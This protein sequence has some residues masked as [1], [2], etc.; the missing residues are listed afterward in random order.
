MKIE[1]RQIPESLLSALDVNL[2]TGEI[3][4]AYDLNARARKGAIAGTCKDGYR[5]ICFEYQVWLGHRIVW[6]KAFGAQNVPDQIDHIDNNPSN[7]ALINL[8]AATQ[9]QNN[10]N[11]PARRQYAGKACV[12]GRKGVTRYVKGEWT[13]WR[14]RIR[15][16]GR[17]HSLGYFDTEDAAAAAYREAERRFYGDFAGT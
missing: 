11:V 3:R 8:R 10:I 13:R 14:A 6:A 2:E 16:G 7:N 9:G 4:W 12:S 5:A 1:R 15:V 17:E